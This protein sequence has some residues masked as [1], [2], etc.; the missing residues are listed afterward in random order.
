MISSISWNSRTQKHY[1][2]RCGVACSARP[3]CELVPADGVQT[4]RNTR[5]ARRCQLCILCDGLPRAPGSCSDVLPA[6]PIPPVVHGLL[7]SWPLGRP[8]PVMMAGRVRRA[9]P[10]LRRPRRRCRRRSRDQ[11]DAM[12]R[13][14]RPKRPT[15]RCD[16]FVCSYRG[17]V[18]DDLG[19]NESADIAIGCS[20]APPRSEVCLPALRLAECLLLATGQVMCQSSL[21]P[22]CQRRCSVAHAT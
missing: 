5:A 16:M 6:V 20:P 13:G 19:A 18:S 22:P 17:R 9:S 21:A 14:C 2:R 12:W 8:A 10:K 11:V 15:R 1:R 3:P 4:M 7:S